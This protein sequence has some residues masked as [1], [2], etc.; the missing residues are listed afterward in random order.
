MMVEGNRR[1]TYINILDWCPE[2]F[3]LS[4]AFNRHENC[5]FYLLSFDFD[6]NFKVAF[7]NA[8]GDK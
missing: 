1:F 7:S 3:S 6:F 4:L 8:V 5:I 2:L